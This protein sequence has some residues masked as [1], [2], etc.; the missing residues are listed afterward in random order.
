MASQEQRDLAKSYGYSDAE[1]DA[2]LGRQSSGVTFETSQPGTPM[3]ESQIDRTQGAPAAERMLALVK[4]G[5]MTIGVHEGKIRV[6]I[7]TDGWKEV[8]RKLR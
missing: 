4:Q 1:I 6:G 7:T 2:Y 3:A 8:S 5:Y